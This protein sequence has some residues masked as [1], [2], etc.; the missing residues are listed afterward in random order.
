[1]GLWITQTMVKKKTG[2]G[3]TCVD[4]KTYYEAPEIKTVWESKQCG[5]GRKTDRYTQ[6]IN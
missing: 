2:W 5:S 1:M 3:L 6:G 4:F